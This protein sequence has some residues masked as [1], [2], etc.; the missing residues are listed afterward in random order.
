MKRVYFYYLNSLGQ[1]FN[2]SEERA[3]NHFLKPLSE[4][5]NLSL[6]EQRQ[7][8]LPSGP[9]FLRHNPFLNFFFR[10]LKLCNKNELE[11]EISKEQLELLPFFPYQSNCKGE[12][13]LMNAAETP[14]VYHSCYPELTEECN[15]KRSLLYAG[16]SSNNLDFSM[17]RVDRENG[18][19]YYPSPN[20]K[21]GCDYSLIASP[22]A[23]QIS[24]YFIE[25][26]NNE[27]DYSG[28]S[29]QLNSDSKIFPLKYL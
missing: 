17:I 9:T 14:F 10:Q 28:V 29:I 7:M 16:N 15:D 5:Q 8:E 18:Q 20:D 21:T 3:F 11:Q 22:L 25:K 23:I 19:L 13:N 6:L 27:K 2:L 24:S 1:L 26:E 12:I 4:K